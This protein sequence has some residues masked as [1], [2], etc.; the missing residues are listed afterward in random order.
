MERLTEIKDKHRNWKDYTY[1]EFHAFLT[2]ILFIFNES[3]SYARPFQTGEY[4]VCD[5]ITVAS[6]Q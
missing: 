4:G 5:I 6:G 2:T 1:T 3:L